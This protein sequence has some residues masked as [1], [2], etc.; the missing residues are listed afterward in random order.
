MPDQHSLERFVEAWRALQ[1]AT[2][3]QGLVRRLTHALPQIRAAL[4]KP[5]DTTP[6]VQPAPLQEAVVHRL[7]AVMKPAISCA[8][9]E[10]ALFNV[11]S[12]AR[13][14]RDEVRN[15]AVLAALFNPV[16]SGDRAVA[17][18]NAFLDRVHGPD[19]EALPTVDELKRGYAVQTEACPL[20]AA[21]DRVD[22]S[23]EG[24]NF[25]LLIE[26]KIDAGEG[27]E[28][29]GRYDRV[30]RTKAAALGKRA[31]LVYL[32]PTPALAPPVDAFY[33]DWRCVARAARAVV[34]AQPTTN[35]TF[36]DHLLRQFA[37]HATQF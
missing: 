19:R 15:S 24:P 18:L 23:I 25:L 2:P 8:R 37:Q 9:D 36:H 28:Q 11:W 14:R 21:D 17:F 7:I 33:A 13:L 12:I 5:A 4:P 3:I 22:L 34:Q 31:A 10:G 27:L 26:V 30:L 1:P 20:G 6:I 32:S 29:L 35:Q 16:V